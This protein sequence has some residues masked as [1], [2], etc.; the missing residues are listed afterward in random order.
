MNVQTACEHDSHSL[1]PAIADTRVRGVGP[2]KL[3]ADTLYGS[4]A[5]DR[6]SQ[7]ATVELVAP[8]QKGRGKKDLLSQFRFDENGVST[9]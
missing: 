3:L 1:A 2:E 4:D 5:N 7:A 6:I 9:L 8:T